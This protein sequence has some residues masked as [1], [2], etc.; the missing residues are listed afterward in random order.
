MKAA[1]N[2]MG[3]FFFGIVKFCD[4]L[5]CLTIITVNSTKL[6]IPFKK[7]ITKFSKNIYIDKS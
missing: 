2:F 5:P 1:C 3:S 6:Y 7:F 4:T